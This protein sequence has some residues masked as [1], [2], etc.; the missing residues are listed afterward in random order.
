[1]S[2]SIKPTQILSQLTEQTTD[3]VNL[4][5]QVLKET[6]STNRIRFE[7]DSLSD[8][9]AAETQAI[10]EFI[11]QS[12]QAQASERGRQLYQ[13]GLGDETILQLGQATRKFCLTQLPKD[14]QL[15]ALDVIETYH[16]RV[17]QGF[18]QARETNLL[19]KQEKPQ[20][21][22]TKEALP[23]SL[24]MDVAA[25][26]TKATTSIL[27]A[28]EL[29]NTSVTLIQEK[30]DFDYVCLFLVDEDGKWAVLK[31]SS[32]KAGQ[33]MAQK[34]YKLEIEDQSLIGWGI[35][36]GQAR[37]RDIKADTPHDD[38]LLLP[39]TR[40]E[41]ALP[42]I[43]RDAVIGAM[44]IQSKQTTAFLEQDLDILQTIADQLAIAIENARLFEHVGQSQKVAED[45]LHETIALQQLSQAL[46]GTFRL[47]EI[48]DIFFQTCTKMLGFDFVIFSLV[49]PSQQRIKAISGV[50]VPD[51]YIKQANYALD[52]PN[53]L[54]DI[55]RTSHTEVIIGWDDR[56]DKASFE[57]ENQAE[58]GL[59]V[60]TPLRLRQENIG[61]VET[62]YN[63][64]IEDT[65]EDG[66]IRLLRSFIDQTALALD[67][68]KRYEASQRAIRREALIKEF[69]TKVRASTNLDTILQTAVKEI[70]DAM[71]RKRTYVHLISPT[72]GHDA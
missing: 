45:L 18:I 25:E 27:D 29:L 33:G 72:N 35:I 48:L 20:P 5:N 23:Y 61:V 69:T 36:N 68:I 8:L 40:S 64:N 66:Q 60:F 24:Q 57:A 28:T 10:L 1:M 34:D 7:P 51:T 55:V 41:I 54:A 59:R 58:W 49:E 37:I 21:D 38:S 22:S 70:G 2:K 67:N 52:S 32:G 16:N 26:I 13:I 19:N 47:D 71:H 15:S 30:F 11:E 63:R 62:G 44:N 50:G 12:N 53:I 31:A 65:I 14:L 6:S 46:S 43:T 17:L 3:L 9:A 56:L 42:L 39:E 4:Y